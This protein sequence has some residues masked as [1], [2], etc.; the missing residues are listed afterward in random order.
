MD[1]RNK[2]IGS[3]SVVLALFVCRMQEKQ[4]IKHAKRRTKQRLK[5]DAGFFFSL[6]TIF[7][8]T[9]AHSLTT[10]D[11]LNIHRVVKHV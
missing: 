11:F 1:D 5:T 4:L 10:F 6:N 3:T 9:T 8:E 7:I 2:S